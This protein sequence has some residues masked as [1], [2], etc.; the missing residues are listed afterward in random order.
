MWQGGEQDVRNVIGGVGSDPAVYKPP[1]PVAV[2]RANLS[3]SRVPSDREVVHHLAKSL[4][5]L[6]IQDD[7]CFFAEITAAGPTQALTPLLQA[8]RPVVLRVISCGC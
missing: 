5:P 2:A 3:K 7:V 4:R 6:L 8:S 1:K